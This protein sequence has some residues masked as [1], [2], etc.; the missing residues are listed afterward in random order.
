MKKRKNTINLNPQQHVDLLLEKQKEHYHKNIGWFLPDE[1]GVSE[2]W[3][4]HLE[5]MEELFG[6]DE[7]DV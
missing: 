1:N 5:D 7:D 4:S 3:N 6:E 2:L